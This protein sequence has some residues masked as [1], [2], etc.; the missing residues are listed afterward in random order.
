MRSLLTIT[1][2]MLVAF[3]AVG[4]AFTTSA[5]YAARKTRLAVEEHKR[6]GLDTQVAYDLCGACGLTQ[7]EVEKII[8]DAAR[9]ALTEDQQRELYFA[10]FEDREDAGACLPCVEAVLTAAGS[11][12]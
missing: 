6:E 10:T 9:S 8:D 1:I 5:W 12:R 4:A 2:V 11:G 7:G 3:L